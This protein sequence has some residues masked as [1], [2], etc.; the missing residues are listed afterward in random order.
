MVKLK[1]VNLI[2][3]EIL[4]KP[5][6]KQ[7]LSLYKKSRKFRYGFFAV[8]ALVFLFI[9]QFAAV[10]AQQLN[11]AVSK[12]A[13]QSAKAKLSQL[14]A[15]YLELEKQK[16]NL[17]KEQNA[18]KQEWDFLSST[19]SGGKKYSKIMALI[20]SFVPEDMWINHFTFGGTQIQIIGSM[21]DNQLVTQFM[22]NLDKSGAFKNSAFTYSE[23]QVV[24]SH[25][26]YNFQITT[27]P[28]WGDPQVEG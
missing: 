7:F 16:A 23:K 11:L 22:N 27:E 17:I 26:I 13:A 21:L 14:Q 5:L 2:P 28:V 4:K 6:L 15:Q 9:L 10:G 3:R 8:A 12:N 25:T 1:S 24:E 18:R 19:L 20:S